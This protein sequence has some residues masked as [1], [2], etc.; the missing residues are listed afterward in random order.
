MQFDKYTVK[1]DIV[2]LF[3]LLI[4]LIL[5]GCSTITGM[6]TARTYDP[7]EYNYAVMIAT[8]AT[9]AVHR[10]KVQ[11]T[12][13]HGYLQA[14]NHDTLILVEYVSNKKDAEQALPAARQIRSVTTSFMARPDRSVSYCLHKINSIQAS[15]RMFARGIATSTQFNP[16]DGNPGERLID[17]QKSYD[18]KEITKEEFTDLVSDLQ[19]LVTI[20]ASSC[21]LANRAKMDKLVS[22]LQSLTGLLAI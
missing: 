12:D 9:H 18:A 4:I 3:T 11:G 10:C 20:D 16:C 15:A 2:K 14:M 17:F 19:K 6:F 22:D 21:T 5:T 1:G 13:Y 8:N 7:V